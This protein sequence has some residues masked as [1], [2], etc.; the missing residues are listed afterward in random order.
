MRRSLSFDE[1]GHVKRSAAS[2]KRRFS[3][4]RNLMRK[5]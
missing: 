4:V 3:T 1:L 5:Q 2:I